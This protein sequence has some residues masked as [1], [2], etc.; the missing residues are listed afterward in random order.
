MIFIH[1]AGK[2]TIYVIEKPWETKC[3]NFQI[4]R[5]Y[6][7]PPCRHLWAFRTVGWSSAWHRVVAAGKMIYHVE[8]QPKCSTMV[9]HGENE[10]HKLVTILTVVHQSIIVNSISQAEA[11]ECS[12]SETL[13]HCYGASTMIWYSDWI[14]SKLG[15]LFGW[16]S[17]SNLPWMMWTSLV[18]LST[19]SWGSK[20]SEYKCWQRLRRLRAWIPQPGAQIPGAQIAG[21]S[22]FFLWGNLGKPFVKDGSLLL[23]SFAI[24]CL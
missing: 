3:I 19:R 20:G 13:D 18:K 22:L 23:P 14:S 24:L 7:T 5:G 21:E 2:I 12:D 1:L 16:Y 6:T 9:N 11:G 4:L 15:W 17:V 10:F 8:S